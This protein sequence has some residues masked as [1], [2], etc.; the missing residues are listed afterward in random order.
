MD[1]LVLR[2]LRYGNAAYPPANPRT[3]STSM[4]H[5]P[6]FG[7][8]RQRPSAQ[9]RASRTRRQKGRCSTC[10]ST[11]GLARLQRAHSSRSGSAVTAGWTSRLYVYAMGVV[12]STYCAVQPRPF[13][14]LCVRER[15]ASLQCRSLICRLG[16]AKS[17]RQEAPY[18]TTVRHSQAQR[19]DRCTRG[20]GEGEGSI[21]V[22]QARLVAV[23]WKDGLCISLYLRRWSTTI[24]AGEGILQCRWTDCLG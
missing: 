8:R 1:P 7:K 11:T 6:I 18:A 4:R 17:A 24:G 9:R 3:T 5:R 19:D 10:R 22:L 13:G 14:E 16:P 2:L 15:K 20:E 21:V 23:G 12:S